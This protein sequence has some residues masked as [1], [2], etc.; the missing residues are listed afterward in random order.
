MKTYKTDNLDLAAYLLTKG[1]EPKVKYLSEILC[2]YT[3]PIEVEK[4]AKQFLQG[5]VVCSL[6]KFLYSRYTLKQITKKLTSVQEKAKIKEHKNQYKEYVGQA[7]W[8][9]GDGGAVHNTLFALTDKHILRKE[10]GNMYPSE[11][12]AKLGAKTK[13]AN[14]SK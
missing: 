14:A 1:Y 5:N 10:N 6:H 2:T 9:I 3:Y 4:V 13:L 8:F 11:E 7:Y 12:L